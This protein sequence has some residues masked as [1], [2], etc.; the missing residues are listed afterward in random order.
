MFWLWLLNEPPEP[1]L[2]QV[3]KLTTSNHWIEVIYSDWT[4]IILRWLIADGCDP[5]PGNNNFIFFL[6]LACLPNFVI[7]LAYVPSTH[8]RKQSNERTNEFNLDTRQK[9]MY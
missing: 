1:F 3:T 4:K 8:H 9:K 6:K 7:E 5:K 2:F